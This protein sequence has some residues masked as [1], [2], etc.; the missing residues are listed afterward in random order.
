M[1][2]IVALGVVAAALVIS[3]GCYVAPVM[4]PVG[5]IY[6]DIDSPLTTKYEGQAAAGKTGEASSVSVLGLVAWGDCSAETAAQ[7]G[8]LQRINYCDY[9]FLNVLGVYQRFTVVAHGE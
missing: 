9:R 5:G 3:T 2:N 4:P 8:G 6:S 7:N 1:R